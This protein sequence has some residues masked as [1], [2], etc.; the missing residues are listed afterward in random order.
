VSPRRK[1]SPA[2]A[3]SHE[4]L[5]RYAAAKPGA[6]EDH[7]WEDD[8]VYKVGGKIFVFFGSAHR[9]SA[10]VMVSCGPDAAEWRERYPNAV[11][12]GPYIGRYGWNS[13]L[14]ES[15]V[16]DDELLELIDLSYERVVAGLP[17]SKRPT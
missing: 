1:D 9:E 5:R 11:T 14:L 7:P 3:S 15:E 16:P 8:L 17:K 6:I 13:V 10:S 12:V 4:K 2:G